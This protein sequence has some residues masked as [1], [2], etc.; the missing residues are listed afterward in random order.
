MTIIDVFSKKGFALA[1]KNKTSISVIY[2]FKKLFPKLKAQVW[3]K[4]HTDKF[5]L[6]SRFYSYSQQLLLS[7]TPASPI[8]HS[9]FLLPL[10]S[11]ILTS[12]TTDN[13]GEFINK[14][15]KELYKAYKFKHLT[16]IAGRP[17]SQSVIE[18]WN[19]TLKDTIMKDYTASDTKDW[20]SKLQTML[21]II[22]T[23]IIQPLR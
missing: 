18:R 17:Q 20:S 9:Y 21:I 7:P 14:D 23:V 16:G 4:F 12:K 22:T 8:S 6:F 3:A 13:G 2:A 10:S 15:V 11:I 19:G 1:L 5:Y